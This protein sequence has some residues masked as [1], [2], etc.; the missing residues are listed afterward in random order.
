MKSVQQVQILPRD[1]IKPPFSDTCSCV[2][3]SHL[4][5]V[6]PGGHLQTYEFRASTQVA[7]FK[8]GLEA[9]S[10]MFTSQFSPVYPVTHRHLWRKREHTLNVVAV[11]K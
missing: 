10:L 3:V 7:W 1:S 6:K 8:Q 11:N 5:P 4:L 9:Q 2:P